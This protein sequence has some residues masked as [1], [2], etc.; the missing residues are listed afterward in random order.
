MSDDHRNKSLDALTTFSGVIG[1]CALVYLAGQL[2]H[3]SA[4]TEIR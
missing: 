2:G 1:V 3:P 4:S